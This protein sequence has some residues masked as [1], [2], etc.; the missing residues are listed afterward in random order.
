VVV[1]VIVGVDVIE[2]VIV[3][4]HLNVNATVGVLPSR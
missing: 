4:V 3:T 1:D 2:P